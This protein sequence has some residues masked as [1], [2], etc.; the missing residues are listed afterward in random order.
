MNWTVGKKMLLAGI[1]IVVGLAALAA[2]SYR[3]NSATHSSWVETELRIDQVDLL[4]K[5]ELELSHLM[6]AAMDSIIDKDAGKIEEERYKAIAESVAFISANLDR[7]VELADTPEALQRS[8]NW[9]RKSLQPP[10][11]RPRESSRSTRL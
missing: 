2:N 7:L 1:V 9:W 8:A 10:T 5:M 4:N 3:T 6:L 11:N